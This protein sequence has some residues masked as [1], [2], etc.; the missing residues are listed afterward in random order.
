MQVQVVV[1][2]IVI[3]WCILL[4]CRD[5]QQLDQKEQ[6]CPDKAYPP[7]H[8]GGTA[9]GDCFAEW[10]EGVMVQA[11]NRTVEVSSIEISWGLG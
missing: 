11:D 5:Q 4:R 7:A 8:D 2:D 9:D 10:L 1:L 3:H 6:D